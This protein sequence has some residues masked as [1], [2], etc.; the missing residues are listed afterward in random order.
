MDTNKALVNA[1]HAVA[2]ARLKAAAQNI[3]RAA[4]A[5]KNGEI[6][7]LKKELENLKRTMPAARQAAAA[8]ETVA[9]GVPAA[10]AAQIAET[11]AVNAM[12]KLINNIG[13]GV[14]N[15]RIKSSDPFALNGI[16]TNIPG[17]NATRKNN[18]QRAV[19]QRTIHFPPPLPLRPRP[20]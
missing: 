5:A 4:N 17:Y 14:H 1:V 2:N 20:V 11:Q 8:A 6:E 7:K 19:T 12:N 13:K 10:P 15:N 16:F 18:I 3:S 9:T